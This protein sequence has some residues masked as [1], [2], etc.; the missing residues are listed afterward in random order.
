MSKKGIAKGLTNYGDQDFSL[1]LR[2]SFARS[3]GLSDRLL[4]APVIGIAAAESGFNNCHRAMPELVEA[5]SRGVLAAGGLPRVFPTIS[6]G[7]VFL[8]PTS[9][10]FRN[11]MAMDTEEMIRAQPMDAVVLIGGCDKT[12]PAQL[13]GALSANVPAV[14]LVTGPMS[15]GRHK[16]E[17]LG[18]CT[19]CRRFWGKYRGGEIESDEIET[20]EG[21]LAVTTG[22]CAV[23]GTA[24][25]MA[26]I[27]ETLGMAL[28]G[29]AAIPAVHSAR[30]LAA[31]ASGR[32]AMALVEKPITPRQLITEKSV[33]NAL[34]ILMAIGG[35]TNAIVH[36]AAVAGRAGIRIAYDRLN[37]ISDTTPVLVDLKPVGDG[38]M[39]DLF[40]AGGVG[41]VLRELKP[42]LHLDTLDVEGRTLGERLEK[43]ID[44]VD[45]KVVREFA[46]PISKVGGLIALSGNLAPDGAIFKRAA[47]TEA[48]FEH[49]GRAVVFE[50][51][52]DLANRID[53]P[54]LDV[55]PQDVLVLKNAG[56][57][58]SGMP[59]AGYLPIPKKLARQG[60]KDMLRISDA[61]MS[62]TAFGTVVLHVAPEAAVGGPLA[63]VRNGD[64]I[65]LSIANKRIDLLVE[66]DEIARRLANHTPPPPPD[67]GYAALYHRSVTQAP[68]GCDF[69]FLAGTP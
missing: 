6:L 17:R 69:D 52:E 5:V 44:W 41:A 54:G 21:R 1:Y 45:R 3:M 65:R 19:D 43:K 20:I 68:L 31:E 50:S 51:L 36:L 67:R 24:S 34:R 18:A 13:M 42:L 48:L 37:Q 16:G 53:D 40:A 39:E 35:S 8:N 61:R 66:K 38:Y 15:T 56:P 57:K 62:G 49:E 55:T 26:C 30:L 47:A 46:N 2:R 22:T 32:A 23:M 29:S 63:A 14:Q 58:A 64:R 60:V 4:A 11:L 9:M 33:E 12:V 59:E 10:M 25:T 27:A 28:P 7:E